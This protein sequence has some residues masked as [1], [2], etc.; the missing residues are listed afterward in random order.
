MRGAL[1]NSRRP[2][3]TRLHS[4]AARHLLFPPFPSVPSPRLALAVRAAA[5]QV[6]QNISGL[7]PLAGPDNAAILQFV[8]NAS[9][10]AITE[11]QPPLQER[12]AGLLLTAN[13]LD[14]LLNNAFVFINATLLLE[15]VGRFRKLLMN[16]DFI[17]RLALPG[18]KVDYALDFNIRDERSLRPDQFS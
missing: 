11:T 14:A 5:V 7:S 1:I 4:E 6:Y 15:V 13:D 12:D 8:H 2:C 17:A 10:A 16:F 3:E 9:G 18:D